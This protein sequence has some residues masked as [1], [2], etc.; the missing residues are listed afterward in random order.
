[1][2]LHFFKPYS[3]IQTTFGQSVRAH[4]ENQWEAPDF[5][6]WSGVIVT[7][8]LS[9]KYKFSLLDGCGV[10]FLWVVWLPNSTL[11]RAVMIEAAERVSTYIVWCLN[12]FAFG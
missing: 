5:W 11:L 6:R 4:D 8:N 2:L 7:A 9:G 10:I 1:L 3:R 12:G